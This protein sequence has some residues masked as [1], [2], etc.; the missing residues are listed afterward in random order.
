[1][2]FR[3]VCVASDCGA[4]WWRRTCGLLQLTDLSVTHLTANH[5]TTTIR[6]SLIY[7]YSQNT[8]RPV[9][10]SVSPF[11]G[12]LPRTDSPSEPSEQCETW[13]R[14]GRGSTLYTTSSSVEQTS[15]LFIPDMKRKTFINPICSHTFPQTHGYKQTIPNKIYVNL[16][17]I[18]TYSY[19]QHTHITITFCKSKCALVRGRNVHHYQTKG[20]NLF[21]TRNLRTNASRKCSSQ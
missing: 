21:R 11:L 12:D 1:M 2:A 18:Y 7:A 3:I 4:V 9:R 14:V 20:N 6:S 8:I 5:I 13:T 19:I 17:N 15:V 10:A 16:K